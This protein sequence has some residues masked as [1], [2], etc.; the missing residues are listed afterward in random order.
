MLAFGGGRRL[1]R[2]KTS[3]CLEKLI[4]KRRINKGQKGKEVEKQKCERGRT[5][6]G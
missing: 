4:G 1:A 5:S 6:W 3:L 2:E